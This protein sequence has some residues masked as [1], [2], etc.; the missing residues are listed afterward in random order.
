MGAWIETA[1]SAAPAPLSCSRA[2]M[3]AWIETHYTHNSV[4]ERLSRLH[5]RVD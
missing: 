5:G 4:T 1:R 3:G 2:F